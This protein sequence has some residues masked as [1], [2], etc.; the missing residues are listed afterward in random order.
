MIIITGATGFIGSNLAAWLEAEGRNDVILV[1][2]LGSGDKWKNIAKRC[3]QDLVPPEDLP[4]IL[5]GRQKG[6]EAVF[7]LGANSSTTATDGDE[8]VRTNLR[9]SMDLWN[10]CADQRV[11]L[12]YA[13]SAATYGD[14]SQGFD[15]TAISLPFDP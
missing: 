3:F 2:W 15:D 1:D 14:G 12:F 8:I 11:P 9:L 13:S 7:H 6:I 5:G 4:A 10:W